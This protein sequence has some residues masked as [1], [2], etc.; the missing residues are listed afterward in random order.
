MI[1]GETNTMGDE[2]TKR[3]AQEYLAARLSEEGQSYEEKL[4][5]EAAVALAP[6]VWKSFADTVIAKCNEWN[7]V[8]QEQTLT[9][10]ETILGDLRILCA[11]RTQQMTVHYDS[12]KRLIT[13]RNTARLEHEPEVILGIEGYATG[14]GR[15]A[16]VVRN[17]EPVNLDMLILGQLRVL[18]GLARKAE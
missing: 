15:K 6:A 14:T 17:N 9:Y 12:K 8:T 2:S 10:K 1:C 13:V 5:M 16:Q 7:A 4:N 18:A 11:G 3:A